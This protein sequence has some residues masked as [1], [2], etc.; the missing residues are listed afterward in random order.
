MNELQKTQF[1]IAENVRQQR[2]LKGWSQKELAKRIGV[3]QAHVSDIENMR[4]ESLSLD[5]LHS[6]A[7]VFNLQF[8]CIFS[9]SDAMLYRENKNLHEWSDFL[10]EQLGIRLKKREVK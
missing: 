7:K 10:R 1:R 9:A 2:T 6:L 4:S 8:S 5:T 3:S